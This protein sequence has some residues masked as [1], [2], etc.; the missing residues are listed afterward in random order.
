M[1]SQNLLSTNYF[2]FQNKT[3]KSS[4]N[5][6]RSLRCQMQLRVSAT[7]GNQHQDVEKESK[8][9]IFMIVICSLRPERP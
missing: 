1:N 8:K 2:S 5:I 3:D 9:T 4:V 7:K 6:T